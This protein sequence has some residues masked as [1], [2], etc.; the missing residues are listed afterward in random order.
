MRLRL[1][2]LSSACCCVPTELALLL[3][4]ELAPFGINEAADIADSECHATGIAPALTAED[5]W[6]FRLSRLVL[7]CSDSDAAGNIVTA[8]GTGTPETSSS[9][10]EAS[11]C[12]EL[13]H[14]QSTTSVAVK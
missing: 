12:L 9:K 8:I 2:V 13:A 14:K 3:A 5:D 7:A 1:D 6:T 4:E 11:L 10:M